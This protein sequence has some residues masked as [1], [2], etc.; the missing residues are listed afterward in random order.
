MNE[1]RQKSDDVVASGKVPRDSLLPIAQVEQPQVPNRQ[2][3]DPLTL[4]Q[5]MRK[6]G[7]PGLSLAIIRDFDIECAKAYGIA[8]VE[9][10]AAVDVRTLFQAASISKAV[11]AVAVLKAAQDGRMSLDT[12]VNTYL[13]SWKIP[14]GRFSD[15]AVTARALLGHTSGA[16]DGFGFPGYE[17][18][19]PRPTLVQILNGEKPSN[20]GPVRFERPPFTSY[21]Y[22]GGGTTILQLAMLDVFRRP[23]AEIMSE[24]VFEPL[25]MRDSTFEQP[26]PSSLHAKAARAHDWDGK[27]KDNAKWHVHPEQAAAGLWTTPTDL[28]RLAIEIQQALRGSG[29]RVLGR[30][31]AREMITPVGMGPYAVGTFIRRHGEGWYFGHD[32]NNWGLHCRLVAHIHKG[33]GVVIMTNGDGGMQVIDELQNRVAA[34]YDW[35]LLHKPFPR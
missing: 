22:S 35:D 30:M 31:A 7:V 16:D 14:R 3:L 32:G 29:S 8:D 11:T 9:T 12:D 23:F 13:R 26:L 2:G 15:S 28:A 10:N 33:Y 27:A 4:E 24:H 6:S 1:Q 17:P 18:S 21:K 20:V 25:G 34:A 5:V 19:E